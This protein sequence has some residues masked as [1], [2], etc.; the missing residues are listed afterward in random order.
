M[1]R[2]KRKIAFHFK[3]IALFSAAFSALMRI[4]RM[5]TLSSEN[6]SA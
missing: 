2:R 5:T 4:V 3:I 1:L 6:T